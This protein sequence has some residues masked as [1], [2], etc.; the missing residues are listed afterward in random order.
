MS[1]EELRQQLQNLH[2]AGYM[3]GPLDMSN[4]IF[5]VNG[6]RNTRDHNRAEEDEISFYVG[7]RWF[8]SSDHKYQSKKRIE[9]D[10]KNFIDFCSFESV[11][12]ENRI[13][14]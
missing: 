7:I 1:F 4:V 3:Y 10:W 5:G 9:T 6:F 13:A 8:V 12:V 14:I 2:R 11:S